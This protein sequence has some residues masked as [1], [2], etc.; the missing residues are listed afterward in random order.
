MNI[1]K[2]IKKCRNFLMPPKI[3]N[4]SVTT[5]EPNEHLKDQ[6]ILVTGG[7]SG[8][9]KSVAEQAALQGAKVIIVGRRREKLVDVSS[10]IGIEKCRYFEADITKIKN[11][12]EFYDKAENIFSLP[13]TGLVNNAGAYINKGMFDF[14]AEDYDHIF[15]LNLKASMFLIREYVKYCNKNG[16]RG[17]IVVTGSNRGLFGDIGPYGISKC[18]IDSYV[19]GMARELIGAGIRINAVAPGMTASEINNIDPKGNMYASSVKGHRVLLPDEIAEVIC[20]L[21]SDNSKCI[22]GA[23]IPCDEGERLR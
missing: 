15:N 5:S 1:K 12:Q 20:F 21:L 10:S 7:G 17:G 2:F 6:V 13:I 14:S 16:I 23:I 4:V 19:E 3:V 22:T 11:Y 9:G 8:I 18:A